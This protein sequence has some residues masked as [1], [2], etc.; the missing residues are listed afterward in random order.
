MNTQ[1]LPPPLS[2]NHQWIMDP[3]RYPRFGGTLCQIWFHSY[4][5]FGLWSFEPIL[6]G[7]PHD[8]FRQVLPPSLLSGLLS[9]MRT[10]WSQDHCPAAPKTS[11]PAAA[12]TPR[13]L[14]AHLSPRNEWFKSIQE[15]CVTLVSRIPGTWW[16]IT[17]AFMALL[18][19]SLLL[20]DL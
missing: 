4:I 6:G 9:S 3:Q 15:Y 7:H 1:L 5:S 10:F 11:F 14:L 13:L 20:F 12:R 8:T 2:L 18:R 16:L 17:T 19:T